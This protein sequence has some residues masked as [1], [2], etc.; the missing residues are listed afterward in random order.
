MPMVV[1]IAA[2]VRRPMT[3]VRRGC[4]DGRVVKPV[5][6]VESWVIAKIKCED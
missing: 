2:I 3:M 1:G 6:A 5:L 4:L